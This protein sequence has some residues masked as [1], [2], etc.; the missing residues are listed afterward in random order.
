MADKVG[1]LLQAKINPN[2]ITNIQTQINNITNALS[3]IKIKIE[4]D[5]TVLASIRNINNQ[6]KT[7]I[8]NVNPI[9]GMGTSIGEL[10][11][12]IQT[13]EQSTGKLLN[14]V[15]DIN[16]GFTDSL[17]VIDVYDKRT[18]DLVSTTDQL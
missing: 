9:S 3:P 2:S 4:I 8:H 14:V 18:G 10:D 1:M 15:R 5:Q 17:K 6:L 13:T 11:K 12:Y 16:L 7:Q